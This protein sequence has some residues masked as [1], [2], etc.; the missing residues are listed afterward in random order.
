MT[1]IFIYIIF[2]AIIIF[3]IFLKIRNQYTVTRVMRSWY[4]S[5]PFVPF[6]VGV[7]F[8]GHFL[9]LMPWE[10][11][12]L[13]T[14]LGLSISGSVMIALSIVFNVFDIKIKPRWLILLF[15]LAGYLVG[16]CFW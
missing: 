3:D 9:A 6:T 12:A 8:L 5:T 1:D 4:E 10:P 2:G 13:V 11:S 16:D 7:I 14:I 15:I